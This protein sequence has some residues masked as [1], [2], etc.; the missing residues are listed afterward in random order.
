MPSSTGP[1][2][3]GVVQS[4]RT[5]DAVALAEHL[6]A[7][8]GAEV[9]LVCAYPYEPGGEGHVRPEFEQVVR[10]EAETLLAEAAASLAGRVAVRTLAVGGLS[11]AKVLFDVAERESA[12]AIVIASTHRGS[13][14]RVATGTVADRLLTGAPCPVAVA[15]HGYAERPWSGAFEH[16]GAAFAPTDAGR[17]AVV[18]AGRLARRAGADLRVLAVAEPRVL[19]RDAWA[20]RATAEE[21]AAAQHEIVTARATAAAEAVE[22]LTPAVEV[23]EGDPVERLREAATALDLLVCGS[24]DYGPASVVLVGGVSK[25][26][27]RSA[28]CPVLVVARD[29]STL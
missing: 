5:A 2:V 29:G 14:G 15:P 28:P 21:L 10:E 12:S 24:R 22:G 3:T 7:A 19:R 4:E 9:L 26:L 20:G 6:A 16:V 13:S 8:A 18:E 11:A 1:V 23:L 27:V 25:A 17:R